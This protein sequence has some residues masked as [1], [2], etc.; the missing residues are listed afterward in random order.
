MIRN[1]AAEQNLQGAVG[2]FEALEQ[3]GVD[4]NPVIYGAV[5][6]A[7]V[8]CRELRAAEDWRERMKKASMA[9]VVS[10]NTLSELALQSGNF[11]KVRRWMVEMKKEGL[12]PT[13]VNGEL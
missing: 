12:Q 3:S 2:V 7:C 1:C 11:D 5:L 6:D 9:D 13:R 4:L 8:E 10:C